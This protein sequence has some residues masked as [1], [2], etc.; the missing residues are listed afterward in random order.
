MLFRSYLN[1]GQGRRLKTYYFGYDTSKFDET[2][3]E[4]I[5]T[6]YA[7]TV[8]QEQT[9]IILEG[10]MKFFVWIS[11]ERWGFVVLPVL[12]DQEHLYKGQETFFDFEDDTWELNYFDGRK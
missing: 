7:G 5:D 9:D 1:D 8:I 12:R 2:T 6:L 10:E 11:R 3:Q 4:E